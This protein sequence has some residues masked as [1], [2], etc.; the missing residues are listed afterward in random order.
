M[1]YRLGFC[2]RCQLRPINDYDLPTTFT[3]EGKAAVT[4][5]SCGAHLWAVRLESEGN[6][7]PRVVFRLP[8]HE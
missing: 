5:R 1:Q 6:A 8:E 7:Q 4:C 3:E 2:P